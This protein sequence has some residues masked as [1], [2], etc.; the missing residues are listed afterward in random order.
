MKN[1]F[2]ELNSL[3]KSKSTTDNIYCHVVRTPAIKVNV[4]KEKTSFNIYFSLQEIYNNKTKNEKIYINFLAHINL[5]APIPAH[6]CDH[7]RCREQL[8][9]MLLL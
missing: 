7:T 5:L 4:K 3:I 6:V 2:D 8:S 1:P 9:M